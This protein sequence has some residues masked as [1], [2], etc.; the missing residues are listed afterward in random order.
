MHVALIAHNYALW[1][2]FQFYA[3]LKGIC[4]IFLSAIY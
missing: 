1:F 2:L 3:S 4:P